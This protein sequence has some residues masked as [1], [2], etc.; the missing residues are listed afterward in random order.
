MSVNEIATKVRHRVSIA[1]INNLGEQLD[2]D[3]YKLKV[4]AKE[5]KQL[6]A[7][8]V[9][10]KLWHKI[11]KDEINQLETSLQARVTKMETNHDEWKMYLE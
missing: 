8:R 11:M 7:Q 6:K 1:G 5:V 9:S 2:M 4:V 10:S 3:D